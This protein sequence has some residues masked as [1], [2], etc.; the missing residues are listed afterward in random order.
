MSIEHYQ[1]KLTVVFI[2]IVK[3]PVCS[4]LRANAVNA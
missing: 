1:G 3:H 4:L 2:V